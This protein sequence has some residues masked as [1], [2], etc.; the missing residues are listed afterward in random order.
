MAGLDIYEGGQKDTW[1]NWQWNR[2]VDKCLLGKPGQ[3]SKNN[4]SE[5]RRRLANKTVL[6]LCGP[7]D[8]DRAIALRHGF[9]NENIIAIDVESEHVELVR[10]N[11]GLAICA[12]LNRVLMSWPAD[13]TID[14]VCAD[15]CG[16]IGRS[17]LSLAFSLISRSIAREDELTTV[18]V[19]LQR[20]RELPKY[21]EVIRGM[22][23]FSKLSHERISDLFENVGDVRRGRRLTRLVPSEDHLAG[24]EK[25]RAK[26]W[27]EFLCVASS[28]VDAQ[29]K[30]DKKSTAQ[31]SV[32]SFLTS[33]VILDPVW[34]SYSGSRVV[35]DS[36]VLNF[37]KRQRWDSAVVD[38]VLSELASELGISLLPERHAPTARKIAA[39]R[40]HRTM[41]ARGFISSKV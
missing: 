8:F 11:S 4:S 6:Y 9:R 12:D 25:N 16:N 17:T 33:R 18:S 21:M 30:T 10:K 14:V 20:G 13:W 38:R 26:V 34:S 23:E 35:M 36:V 28:S 22:A 39:L 27:A 5:K 32:E 19:N 37:L 29:A 15:F 31:R 41:K 3:W 1:R 24:D 7:D 40:A 2:I